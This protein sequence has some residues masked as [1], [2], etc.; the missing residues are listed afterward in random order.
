MR[1]L[2]PLALAALLAAGCGGHRSPATDAAEL[3]PATASAY[4]IVAPNGLARARTLLAT[5][6]SPGDAIPYLRAGHTARLAG[7]IVGF[8]RPVDEKAFSKRL[9]RVGEPH[10]K[11]RGWIVYARTKALVDVVRHSKRSLADTGRYRRASK[12]LPGDALVRAYVV[13]P[14]AAW[15]TAALTTHSH[16]EKLEVRTPAPR[17]ASPPSSIAG[18]IP[19]SAVVAVSS[20][21]GALPPGAS[22]PVHVLSR[23]L[24]AD[25]AA[26]VAAAGGPFVLYAAPGEP[27]PDVTFATAAPASRTLLLGLRA[28]VRAL[29]GIP[30]PK[31]P[32]TVDLGP[33]TLT[34]GR[35]A[36][37]VVLSDAADPAA[38]LAGGTKLSGNASFRAAAKAAA[39]PAANDGFF[40][41]DAKRTL[42]AARA[43][44]AL[45]NRPVPPALERALA[46]LSTLLDWQATGDGV[47]T[48]TYLRVP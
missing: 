9:D 1:R 44:S 45:A 17:A 37:Q 16:D 22:A 41:V 39:L 30:V 24:G 35:I 33:V 48:V 4:V 40:Y 10:A 26:P 36:G 46:P 12:A 34:Y 29:A 20:A 18:E 23:A 19:A 15:R 14:T 21:S 13:G 25:I 7:G 6:G 38:E 5:F 47:R 28:L 42:A 8:A 11:L 31:P 43:L 32:A 2:A 3:V 27:V